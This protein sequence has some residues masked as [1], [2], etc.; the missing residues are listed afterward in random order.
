MAQILE[1]AQRLY[2]PVV[3]V[4]G[5]QQIIEKVIFDGGQLTEER[6]TNARWANAMA[7][8]QFDRLEGLEP[9]FGDWHLKKNLYHVIML[10]IVLFYDH[11]KS[12]IIAP[13]D[14]H[15]NASSIGFLLQP[16]KALG[17][18]EQPI[19]GLPC[20]HPNQ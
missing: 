15:L 12:I 5:E 10:N 14:M 16:A 4:N 13:T 6:S 2:V 20:L 8:T 3:E 18:D 7:D 17:T 11:H 1:N 19:A 9:T